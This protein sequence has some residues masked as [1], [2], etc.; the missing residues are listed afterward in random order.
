MKTVTKL[1]LTAAAFTAFSLC[2]LELMYRFQLVD[3]YAPELKAYNATFESADQSDGRTILVQ[4]DSFTAGSD[5]YPAKMQAALV[6]YRVVNAGVSG[7][8]VIQA[9]IIAP[10]R[11]KTF[12]PDIFI[13]QIYVGN[14]LRDISYPIDWDGL[15]FSRNVYWTIAEVFRSIGY[16]N[17]RLSQMFPSS[18]SAQGIRFSDVQISGRTTNK[19]KGEPDPDAVFSPEEYTLRDLMYIK[20]SPSL[21][22]GA[23]LVR[24]E[25]QKEAY[26][27]L[28][29]ELDKLIR[30]CDPEICRAAILLVPHKA[31]VSAAY[32]DHM[33]QLGMTFSDR[34]AM[35]SKDYPFAKGIH[36]LIEERNL[37]HVTV[38]DPMN[39]LRESEEN[40]R[41]VYFQN[42]SHL[43]QTGNRIL[44][45]FLIAKLDL[46]GR[47]EEVVNK[48]N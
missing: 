18:Q 34:E 23:V 35:Q 16:L 2:A 12:K 43:N 42:D 17:Y 25:R 44:A 41:H 3:C 37:N 10:R 27:R 45:E 11:F 9:R 32:A 30:F 28:L 39:V 13:Y 14:D 31:Q 48:S 1:F 47:P 15:S 26:A 36:D 33:E 8:G 22:E 5:D 29:S 4:G 24:D 38:L 40:G 46:H 6:D 19:F 21:T 20:A 7:T